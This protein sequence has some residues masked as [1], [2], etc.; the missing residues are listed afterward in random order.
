[1]CTNAGAYGGEGGEGESGYL[2]MIYGSTSGTLPLN[3]VKFATKKIDLKYFP[4]R[5]Y[6]S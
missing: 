3:R 2:G 5:N 1:M 4:K 6:G